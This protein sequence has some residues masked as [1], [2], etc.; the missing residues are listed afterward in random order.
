MIKISVIIVVRNEESYI[1]ECIKS[2]EYQFINNDVWELIIVDGDSTDSTFD[3]AQEYLSKGV[4]NYQILRNE[5]RTLAPGWNIGVINAKGSFVCRPDAHAVLNKNYIQSGLEI[6]ENNDDVTV[7]GGILRTKSHGFWGNIIKEAL[8]SKIGVGSSFRTITKSGYTDTAVYAI[9]R[10]EIFDKVGY[11]NEDFVRHQDNDMHQR[12]KGCGGRF[13][14]STEMVADYYCR[15]TVP[16]LLKQMFNIGKF[17]PD[18]FKENSFSI[19]H[20]MPLLFVLGI[21]VGGICGLYIYP[22]KILT[23]AVLILYILAVSIDSIFKVLMRKNIALLFNISIIPMIHI[24]YGIGT[25]VG[26]LK[27]IKL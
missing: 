10:K 1:E 25:L 13:F 15:E 22:I 20:I 23:L 24:T 9:Y 5:K 6:L 26:L 14:T 2:I 21:L 4:Y 12:I 11:F 16:K 18:L 27:K 19:R 8:S 3:I 17:L 7:V